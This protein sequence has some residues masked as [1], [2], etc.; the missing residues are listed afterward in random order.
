M[1]QLASSPS[2]V[3][4]ILEEMRDTHVRSLLEHVRVPTL[5]LDRRGVQCVPVESSRYLATHIPQVHYV[6]L[7]EDDHWWVG[8][9]LPL[10][11]EI[12]RF[13]RSYSPPACAGD[14]NNSHR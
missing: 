12:E 9:T 4:I 5:V 6:E 10:H 7:P 8:G 11:D 14:V 3:K 1:Q 2:A 13:I